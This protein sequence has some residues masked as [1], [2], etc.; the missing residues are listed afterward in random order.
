[1]IRQWCIDPVDRNVYLAVKQ[2]DPLEWNG[3]CQYEEPEQE[4]I[5]CELQLDEVPLVPPA[6]AISSPVPEVADMS[7]GRQ[8][9]TYSFRLSEVACHAV[10][11]VGGE[12]SPAI[13]D[14][15]QTVGIH[16][17]NSY[18]DIQV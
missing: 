13:V 8:R 3:L 17:T 2:V 4:Q 15:L 9:D 18:A 10:E 1:M 5:V 16:P 11:Q 6:P 14:L 12:F 7:L